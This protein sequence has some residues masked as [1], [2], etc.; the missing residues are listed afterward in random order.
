MVRLSIYEWLLCKKSKINA[1]S[2]NLMLDFTRT[3]IK[4]ADDRRDVEDGGCMQGKIRFDYLIYRHVY[5][6]LIISINYVSFDDAVHQR[7]R[8]NVLIVK[9][10]ITV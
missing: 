9:V 4:I 10:D 7:S 5:Y 6:T 8:N 1:K 2:K 3:R